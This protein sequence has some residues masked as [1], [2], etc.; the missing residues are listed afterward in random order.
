VGGN[1]LLR[2]SYLLLHFC[3]IYCYVEVIFSCTSVEFTAT[4][5]LSS[6][7]LLWNLLLRWGYLL[8]ACSFSYLEQ[9]K[10]HMKTSLGSDRYPN[11]RK[12]P[13]SRTIATSSGV[14]RKFHKLGLSYSGAKKNAKKKYRALR[15]LKQ[16][17][18]STMSRWTEARCKKYLTNK[19]FFGSRWSRKCFAC[20]QSLIS[21]Q[22]QADTL[23]CANSKCPQ[24]RPRTSKR[25]EFLFVLCA[26]F[27][28]RAW[29][30]TNQTK[31]STGDTH[32]L[33][34]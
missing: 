5:K 10:L 9:W 29:I 14:N 12:R 11:G 25:L 31:V 17:D 2:W 18:Y 32:T 26:C 23:R 3:G 21:V 6:L 24:L 30:K 33:P 16:T 15:D 7:A 20:R 13:P 19:G 4:L 22:N 34:S 28:H 1:L 27:W 8:C